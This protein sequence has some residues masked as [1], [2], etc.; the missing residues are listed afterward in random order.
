MMKKVRWAILFF[1]LTIGVMVVSCKHDPVLPDPDEPPVIIE[2]CDP[3]T[4]YFQ[5]EIQPLLNSSCGI[6]GCHD[7]GS[8]SD[9]VVL[10]DYFSVIRTADV[11]PGNPNGSDLF[12]VLTEKDPDK[13]MPPP[14]N[15]PLSE[16]Q[17]AKIEKWIR[18]GAK[19]NA[20]ESNNCDTMNVTFS[21]QIW[22]VIQNSCL[23][24]HSGIN[25]SGGLLLTDHSKIVAAT[26][27]GRLL[28]S[29]R[30]ESGY[31]PMPQNLPRLNDCVLTQFQKWIDDGTPEN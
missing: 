4:V 21:G 23:G 25:P 30:H 15:Q 22:P 24:C 27:E 16:E 17:I 14:P 3:D 12:E 5:N 11:R 7:A 20:C 6:A 8:A 28:G 10:T 26:N 18:Q 31:S 2:N 13:R 19:N 9:G 1:I 29:I